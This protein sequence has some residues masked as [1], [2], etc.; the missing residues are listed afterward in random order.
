MTKMLD[1]NICSYILRQHPLSILSYLQHESVGGLAVSSIV[2]AELRFG[3]MKTA[4]SKLMA[5]VD[6]LLS[7]F[8]ILAWTDDASKQYAIIRT[9]LTTSGLMIGNMDLLIAAHAL[10]ENAILVTNNQR[11]FERVAGLTL[12]NWV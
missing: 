7:V 9:Q 12:E 6:G 4:S 3:A 8:N 10:A 11:E 2:A 1:T 5:Q